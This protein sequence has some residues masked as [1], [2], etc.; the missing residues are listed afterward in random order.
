MDARVA[1][2]FTAIFEKKPRL[3]GAFSFQENEGTSP[4]AT[5]TQ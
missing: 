3:V 1:D 5:A 4:L 2:F